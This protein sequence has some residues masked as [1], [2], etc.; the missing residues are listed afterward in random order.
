MP[1]F[2][3]DRHRPRL[4][5]DETELTEPT[6]PVSLGSLLA[7]AGFAAFCLAFHL[8][9]IAASLVWLGENLF[10]VARYMADA[11]AQELPLVGNGD[12]DWTEIFSRW[13]VLPLD[14]RI[15]GFT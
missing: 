10:N 15:A 14:E 9:G 1:E 5:G 2:S 4:A 7:V 12:H 3:G 13:N 6:A 8:F 11:R